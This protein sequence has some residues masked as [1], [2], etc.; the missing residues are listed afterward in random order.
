MKEFINEVKQI[1]ADAVVKKQDAAKLNFPKI[2]EI[3]KA[4]AVR[5]E[6]NCTVSTVQMNEYDRNLLEEEGFSVSL[7]DKPKDYKDAIRQIQWNP[8]LDSKEWIIKW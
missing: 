3:I 4:A 2:M 8:N 6:S 7:V 5:G 1:T